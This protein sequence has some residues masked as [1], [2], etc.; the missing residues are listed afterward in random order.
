MMIIIFMN[1]YYVDQ[2]ESRSIARGLIRA[3]FDV[4]PI[5]NLGKSNYNSVLVFLNSTFHQVTH[6]APLLESR[7]ADSE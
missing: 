4:I 6:V 1:Y 2:V 3:Q 5:M 7:Q